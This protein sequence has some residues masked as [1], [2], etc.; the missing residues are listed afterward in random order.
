M[1]LDSSAGLSNASPTST[2]SNPPCRIAT[3]TARSLTSKVS[4]CLISPILPNE[5]DLVSCESLL[6]KN[7]PL[8]TDRP[9]ESTIDVL[10]PPREEKNNAGGPKCRGC[11][12]SEMGE[13]KGLLIGRE[14]PDKSGGGTGGEIT[15]K[16]W[17]GSM[18]CKRSSL[19]SMYSVSSSRLTG[20]SVGSKPSLYHACMRDAFQGPVRSGWS[21]ILTGC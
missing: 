7:L 15:R 11:S 1:V 20:R 17:V 21:T 18:L 13:S 9:R 14:Y 4:R 12:N 2:T 16:G 6:Q 3:R 19:R 5:E 10:C 8:K